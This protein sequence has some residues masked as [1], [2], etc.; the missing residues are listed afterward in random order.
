MKCCHRRQHA[1]VVVAEV[2]AA[3]GEGAEAAEEEEEAEPERK[4]NTKRTDNSA[5]LIFD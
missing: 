3:E 5:V 2:G 1:N 4:N